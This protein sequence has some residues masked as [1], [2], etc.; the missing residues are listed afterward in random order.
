MIGIRVDANTEIASGH[1]MR[2]VSIAYAMK[3]VG[4]EFIFITADEYT[5]KI[6]SNN[7][8]KVICLH[9]QWNNLDMEIEPLVNVIQ[10]LMI[11]KLI[12]DSYYVT[13]EYFKQLMEH[14]KVVYIDDLN[15]FQYP[16]AMIVNYNIY[17]ERFCYPEMYSETD[18]QLLLGCDYAPLRAEF[19]LVTPSFREEVKKV[20]I[21]TG[22]TDNYNVA[23]KLLKK[24]VEE[25]LFN[26]IEFHVVVGAFNIHVDYIENLIENNKHITIYKNVKKISELMKDCDIAITAGGSTMYELCAC[27]TAAIC[28][29]FADNQLYG[30]KGFEEEDLMYYAGDMRDLDIDC[31]ANIILF[32]QKYIENPKLREERIVN[33]RKKVDGCGAERLINAVLNL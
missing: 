11:D 32:I 13:K 1:V 19:K 17:Y 22:G 21:T 5:R 28:F 20:L 26:G 4:T 9:S 7:G 18:T 33:T 12:I 24:I 31:T 3:N 15:L 16:I 29:S 14:T 8:F 2:C 27:G 10:D 25:K 23:G 30:V 6:I